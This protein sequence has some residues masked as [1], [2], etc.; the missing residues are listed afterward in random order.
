M[1]SWMLACATTVPPE[2]A[3]PSFRFVVLGDR[4]GEPRDVAWRRSV[5]EVERLRPDLVLTVGDFADDPSNPADWDEAFAATAALTAPIEFTPGNHDITDEASEA[6]FRE[7]TGQAPWRSFD[8]GGVHFVIVDNAREGSY[9]DLPKAQRTWLQSDLEAHADTLVAVFM[10]KPFW[11]HGVAADEP[12]AMHE[13]FVANKVDAVFTGHWHSHAHE[14]IDGIDYVLVGQSGGGYPGLSSPRLGNAEE[15]LW[16]TVTEQGLAIA[17][18]QTGSISGPE[19]V[20]LAEHQL[21]QKL[22]RGAFRAELDGSGRLAL[23]IENVA[24][25]QMT[26]AVSVDPGAWGQTPEPLLVDVAPG[27]TFEQTISLQAGPPRWP[28]PR[29]AMTVPVPDG[30][31]VPFEVV[32]DYMRTVR[33]RSSDP[34]TIDGA[35]DEPMWADAAIVDAWTN[36]DGG[37]AAAEPTVAYLL[38]TDDALVIG[39]RIADSEPERLNVFHEARDGNVVY[40]DRFGMMIAPTDTD[41]YWFYITPNASVWDLHADREAGDVHWDWDAVEAAARVTERG[42]QLEARVPW[43]ALGLDGPPETLPVDMRRKQE[44][45]QEEATFTPAFWASDPA[46]M[47]RLVL[48]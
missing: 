42:W 26:G 12:D 4:T 6:L 5:A 18:I 44:R 48:E 8:R 14:V 7:K 40:D 2:T 46:R 13:L 33:V 3:E 47:G 41:L 11:A 31:P 43:A 27:E 36:K 21:F 23:H 34:P 1:L 25:G 37:A 32:A 24:D 30:E 22:W 28:L 9:Q 45:N 38:W 29:V 17:T 15:Y 10:H 19:V 20:S 39:A 35:L 16:V